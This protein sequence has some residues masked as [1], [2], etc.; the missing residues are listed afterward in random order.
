MNVI[1]MTMVYNEGRQLKRWADYYAG[2]LGP[3]SLFVI[4]HGSDDGSLDAL[5][6]V[7]RLAV[8]RSEFDDFKRTEFVNDLQRT[9]L[10][11]FDVVIYTDCDEMIVADPAKFDNLRAF[12]ETMPSEHARPIGLDI[13]HITDM[14]PELDPLRPILSQRRF[15]RFRSAWCKPLITK[16]PLR[17]NIGFH[18]CDK[19]V[20]ANS[21][22]YLFHTKYADRE[23]A[24]RRL[25]V[26][27]SLE[28]P[29]VAIQHSWG[30]HQRVSDERM[31]EAGFKYPADLLRYQG[32]GREFKFDDEALRFNQQ[33]SDRGSAWTCPDFD[34]PIF[35]IP[36][37]LREL[38]NDFSCS[39]S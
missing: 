2:Q 13:A 20:P 16:S 33:L 1:V 11:F 7:N 36:E 32:E 12:V 25:A 30:A 29:E 18:A 21:D 31:L 5:E 28:W 34:G 39:G 4:D 37:R 17:W 22:L 38:F 23:A 35:E 14:E 8:P 19:P 15:C 26:T 9:L 27:R 6:G 10:R 24:L 3:S